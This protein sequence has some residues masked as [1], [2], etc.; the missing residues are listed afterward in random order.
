MEAFLSETRLRKSVRNL[1]GGISDIE[2]LTAR[3]SSQR[4]SPRD[5]AA[6]GRSLEKIPEIKKLLADSEHEVLI[7]EAEQ[8]E[9]FPQLANLI[10]EALVDEPPLLLTEGGVIR[11][12]YNQKLDELRELVF[13]GKDWIARLEATERQ[14]TGIANLKVKY[15][16]VFGYYIE[17]SH[18]SANKV[19]ADYIR[20]QTIKNAERY[21]TSELK[22]YETRILGAEERLAKLEKTV[23]EEI[24]R[25]ISGWAP[26]ILETA[27]KLAYL[28]VL[29]CFATAA[30]LND[31]TKPVITSIRDTSHDT[32]GTGFTDIYNKIHFIF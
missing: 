28:D 30:E 17:V 6:L 12:G 1:L 16:K 15:N 21:I 9:E 22:E 10:K 32:S 5:V 23:F 25:E 27:R 2:R 14:R 7:R 13:E 29:A 26:E 24:C 20:K 18:S 3:T 8:L 19:P 11:K 4:A 31:Y